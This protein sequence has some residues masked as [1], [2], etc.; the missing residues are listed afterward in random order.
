MT[1][2][3]NNNNKQ[4]PSFI[5][6]IL[7]NEMKEDEQFSNPLLSKDSCP[8]IEGLSPIKKPQKDKSMDSIYSIEIYNMNEV[9]N[10][11]VD[12]ERS[13]TELIKEEDLKIKSLFSNVFTVLD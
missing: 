7:Y 5:S 6:L 1:T 10:V 2:K 4:S 8:L 12:L 11:L 3:K 13:T 9:E